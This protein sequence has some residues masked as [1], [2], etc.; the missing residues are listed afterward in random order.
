MKKIIMRI[1]LWIFDLIL[2]LNLYYPY[3][4]ET[5]GLALFILFE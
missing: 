4:L 3:W 5:I 1:K 2:N